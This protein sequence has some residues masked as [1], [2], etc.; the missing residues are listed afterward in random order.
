MMKHYFIICI[1]VLAIFSCSCKKD[2]SSIGLN[3]QDEDILN[4]EFVTAP[5]SA[6]STLEDS[7]N[8]KNL[9]NNVVGTINDPVFGQ[10]QA[11]FCTQF[12]V[13]GSNSF[14][15]KQAVLDSVVLT[16][17]YSGY[18]GDTLSPL[19]FHAY[20]LSQPLTATHYY[21]ND[22][23]P[24]IF[25]A[26]LVTDNNYLYPQPN[27]SV[28]VDTTSKAAHLRLHLERSFGNKL[29]KMNRS[30]L[31]NTSAFQNEFY[32]LCVQAEARPSRTGN[33]CYVSLTSAMSGIT[34]YY[35]VD[36]VHKKYTFPIS[37]DCV[38]YN[39]YTHDYTTASSNFQRQVIQGDT[40]MGR[41]E[42]YLQPTA[43]VKTH[44][45]LAEVPNIF[46]DRNVVI[47][48]AE[49]VL[50]NVSTDED[51]FYQPY[52]LSLQVVD[53]D[54][55][56]YY[57]PDDASMTSSGYF[58]GI[59]DEKTKEYRFRI[60]NYVQYI[61]KNGIK[62]DGLNVVVNGAGVR[63]NRLVF[64]GTDNIYSDNFRLEIYYTE[65]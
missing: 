57:T 31:A 25:S 58:G 65:L 5:L 33:L 39:F 19:K 16:L 45:S 23:N 44:V 13:S 54:G 11:G 2:I 41:D 47:N 64:R 42:L 32:G 8:T 35:T 46:K 62:D 38:R 6:H 12:A 60:T 48:R 14:F 3:L 40:T 52:N 63:G 4:A 59:Y 7:I 1:I 53:K 36:R 21:S 61:I 9:L 27:T 10:T 37:K 22:D 43:G 49:L 20:E 34:V 50:T 51:Y 56:T 24:A 30:Q 15:P 18:F 29:L 17:Q 28:Y 26:D 55:T